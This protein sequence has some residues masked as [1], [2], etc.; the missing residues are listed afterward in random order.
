MAIS[1][2]QWKV[3]EEG[4]KNRLFSSITFSLDGRK[5]TVRWMNTVKSGFSF[6]LFVYID[7]K[8]QPVKG[9][10]E[11]EHFDPFVKKVWREKKRTISLFRKVELKGKTKRVIADLKKK[12]PDKVIVLFDC[13][14][15]TASALIRQYKKLEGLEVIEL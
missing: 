12:F 14:F 10:P 6:K 1:A 8:I 11:S 4:F 13:C 7:E 2:E 9:W 5:L 3:L 15:P